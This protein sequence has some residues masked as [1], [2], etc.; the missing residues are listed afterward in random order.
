MI[1]L[2]FSDEDLTERDK[3]FYTSVELKFEG[4]SQNAYELARQFR[5]FM[6]ALSYPESI[7]N[8]VLPDCE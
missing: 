4:T 5:S 8:E 3:Q 6:Y 7:I 1:I 2:K